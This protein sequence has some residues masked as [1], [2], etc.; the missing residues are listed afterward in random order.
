MP[1]Q[2]ACGH[3]NQCP[4][5]HFSARITA[6]RPI[7]TP[8]P[9]RNAPGSEIKRQNVKMSFAFGMLG[10]LGAGCSAFLMIGGGGST[11]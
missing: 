11:A 5:Q 4:N 2:R 3:D 9:T 1:K 7:D 8:I 6:P 10:A